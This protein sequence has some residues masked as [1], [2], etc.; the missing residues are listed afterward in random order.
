VLSELLSCLENEDNEINN[1][2]QLRAIMTFSQSLQSLIVP[3]TKWILRDS[4][5]VPSKDF[6]VSLT[7]LKAHLM[8][9]KILCAISLDHPLSMEAS[10]MLIVPLEILIRK[11]VTSSTDSEANRP[12]NSD[13]L[14][15]SNSAIVAGENRIIRSFLDSLPSGSDDQRSQTPRERDIQPQTPGTELSE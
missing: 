5:I 12:N 15:P 14:L 11:G 9:S 1:Y 7:K 10:N 2:S 13:K 3:P 6:L 8:I 4:F